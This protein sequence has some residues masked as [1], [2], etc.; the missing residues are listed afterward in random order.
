MSILLIDDSP[1]V[2]EAMTLW[3]RQSGYV[4]HPF[5]NVADAL[6]ALYDGLRPSLIILDL[7]M[8]DAGGFDF[9]AAQ[10]RGATARCR[11][12]E[13]RHRDVVVGSVST[14]QRGDGFRGNCTLHDLAAWAGG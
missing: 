4:V 13:G 5:D 1:D 11:P 12:V 8:P 10:L 6:Q 2:V 7:F 3:L 14:P 9:R